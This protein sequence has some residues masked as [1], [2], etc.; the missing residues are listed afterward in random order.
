MSG[1]EPRSILAEWEVL[2]ER[3]RCCRGDKWLQVLHTGSGWA[4]GPVWVPAGR[5]LV[6]SDVPGD[7]LLRWDETTGAVGVFRSP[8]G[9]A[10]GNTLD[11][12]GRLVTCEQQPRRVTR[13]EHDGTVT[14]LAEHFDG[15]RLNSP[16]DVAVRSDGSIWFTDPTYGI[17]SHYEG[18]KA[19]SEIGASNVY[20]VDAATGSLR[21]VA[22]DFDQPNGLCFSPDQGTLYISDTARAHMRSF[23]VGRDGTLTGGHVF[24]SCTAGV[25]DG[26][27]VDDEGRV[28]A[29]AGDGVHCYDPDGSLIGKV[30]VPEVVANVAFGGQRRNQLFITATTSLYTLRVGARGPSLSG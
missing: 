16:N 15:Q 22:N 29:S 24:A 26:F 9:F 4:E 13:T 11:R 27:R 25:F 20:R 17:Q 6:W 12:A 18:D 5:Y 7:R 10:N 23:T 19:V 28:W 1:E 14:V 3:F 30:R 21:A 8:S 2:D